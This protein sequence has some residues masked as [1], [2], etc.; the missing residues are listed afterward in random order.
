MTNR[1]RICTML[2]IIF[3]LGTSLLDYA[4]SP[5]VWPLHSIYMHLYYIPVILATSVF[6]LRG[7]L[8]TY[9]SVALLYFPYILIRWHVKALFLAEDLLH[10]L[11]L[12]VFAFIAGFLVHREG[13][14][15]Q[16]L[17]RD[18]RLAA[19]GRAAGIL[20]HEL[21]SPLT[22]IMGFAKRI[23]RK[24]DNTE[25]AVR[26]IVDA[27]KTMERIVNSTLDLAKPQKPVF[28]EGEI[29]P[30]IDHAIT[31]CRAKADSHGIRFAVGLP[32]EPMRLLMDRFLLERALV[33]LIDNAIDASGT[34]QLIN[35]AVAAR[36]DYVSIG[37][38]DR[39]RGMDKET[40]EA[41]STPFYTRKPNGTGIGMAIT[42]KIVECHG[43]TMHIDSKPGQGTTI[44]IE[45]PWQV[46]KREF[47]RSLTARP[48]AVLN[49]NG[50]KEEGGGAPTSAK[51]LKQ[52]FPKKT[53]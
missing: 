14:Y 18:L 43:G 44:S 50:L 1:K 30:V 35:V 6:G 27:A 48:A 7:A 53:G 26:I 36:R 22:V 23:Q 5:K 19:V 15:R 52:E 10:M 4:T 11:F 34:G 32:S 29:R 39:G 51:V 9:A 28:E 45:L 20:A 2:I 21:R 3:T 25:T 41:A 31:V 40:M 33:N 38:I 12:G 8:I 17:D 42:M 47:E 13:E 24:S 46:G 37:I 16:R 49:E